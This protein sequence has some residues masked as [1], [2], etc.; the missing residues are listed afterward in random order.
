MIG[1]DWMKMTNNMLS[2]VLF[3]LILKIFVNE[4]VFFVA[5]ET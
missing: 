4:V 1:A 2:C 3:H 5:K